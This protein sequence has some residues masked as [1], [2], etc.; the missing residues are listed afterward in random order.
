MEVICPTCGAQLPALDLRYVRRDV[1]SDIEAG[2]TITFK[3][4]GTNIRIK[5]GKFQIKDEAGTGLWYPLRLIT[6]QGIP[7]TF[8]EPTDGES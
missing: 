5:N 3:D 7:A 4:V 2:V 6:D 1:T 8:I